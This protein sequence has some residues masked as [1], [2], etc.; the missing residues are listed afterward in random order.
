MTPGNTPS[1]AGSRNSL[2]GR[3]S[4]CAPGRK[5]VALAAVVDDGPGGGPDDGGGRRTVTT[6]STNSAPTRTRPTPRH[7]GERTTGILGMAQQVNNPR[8]AGGGGCSPSWPQNRRFG[9][10]RPRTLAA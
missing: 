8:P 6:P 2:P 4:R 9:A 7:T 1:N 10:G 5:G 3:G